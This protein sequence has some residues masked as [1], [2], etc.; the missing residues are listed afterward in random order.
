M[1]TSMQKMSLNVYSHEC[2]LARCWII[3]QLLQSLSSSWSWLHLLPQ[4]RQTEAEA[5]PVVQAH[6]TFMTRHIGSLLH[7][8]STPTWTRRA[9]AAGLPTTLG[10]VGS[11]S[12]ASP[13]V[14]GEGEAGEPCLCKDTEE[15]NFSE[16]FPDVRWGSCICTQILLAVQVFS[17]LSAFGWCPTENFS[18][19]VH[20]FSG[21]FPILKEAVW[22]I[23]LC[24]GVLFSW[25]V[26]LLF[27][28]YELQS[29]RLINRCFALRGTVSLWGLST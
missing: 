23:Y 19:F 25:I 29:I 16:D 21:R 22:S 14:P 3:F 12:E 1:G 6:N 9:A 2:Y 4:H 27:P 28:R 13:Q 17:L 5:V 20:S 15:I 11:A 8:P 26:Y 18:Q 10:R 7:L 24:P